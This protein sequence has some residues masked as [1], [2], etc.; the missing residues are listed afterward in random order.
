M[1]RWQ[2]MA[3]PVAALTILLIYLF[4]PSKGGFPACPFRTFTGMLCPGCGSQRALHDLLHGHVSEAWG[5]NALL[6]TSLPLLALHGAWGRL[7]RTDRPLSSYNG[8]VLAWILL[9]VGW[10]ILRN[11]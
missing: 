11:I 4:D 3:L 7:F 5:H 9:I 10:G 2:W 8:V 1:L 6:V